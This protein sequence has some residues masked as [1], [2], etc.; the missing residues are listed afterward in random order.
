MYKERKNGLFTTSPILNN[1]SIGF[2]HK[3]EDIIKAME[4][5][6]EENIKVI[7]DVPKILGYSAFDEHVQSI[8]N[9][10]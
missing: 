5:I 7:S 4:F 6:L 3:K 2:V 10:P 9:D 8:L 1:M